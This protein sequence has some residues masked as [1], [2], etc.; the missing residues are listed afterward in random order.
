MDH[1]P[2]GVLAQCLLRGIAEQL[3]GL[4]APQHD[5]ALD[6]QHDRGHAEHIEQPA[7]PY[8][9]ARRLIALGH[10]TFGC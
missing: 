7:R 9:P 5:A 3:L 6:V 8:R 2:G 1:D 10:G 4:R